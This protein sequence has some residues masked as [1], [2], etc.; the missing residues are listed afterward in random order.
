LADCRA[1]EAA[2]TPTVLLIPRG[3][4]ETARDAIKAFRLSMRLLVVLPEA[5]YGRSL[6][7]IRASVVSN[8]DEV[9][10]AAFSD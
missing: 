10:L 7:D 9:V 1:L 4:A 6:A 2:G 8:R 3:L 5:L